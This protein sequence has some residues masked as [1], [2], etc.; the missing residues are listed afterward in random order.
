MCGCPTAKENVK[1]RRVSFS[2][3][4]QPAVPRFSIENHP[5]AKD[6]KESMCD[7]I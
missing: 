7:S 3:M 1:I 4:A 5:S 6:L 2:Q